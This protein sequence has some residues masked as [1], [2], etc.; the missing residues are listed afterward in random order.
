MSGEV[1]VRGLAGLDE[2][3]AA[4]T[5][6]R[7][8][9]GHTH[10]AYGLSPHLLAAL[11]A[12]AGSVIGAF[13]A[14][15]ELI[16]FCFGFTAVDAGELYH[17]SQAAVVHPSAQGTGVGRLLKQAQAATARATGA[18]TMRWTFDPYAVRNAHFN[19]AVLGAT[20]VRFLPDYYGGDTDR[21]LV[22]WDLTGPPRRAEPTRTVPGGKRDELRRGLQ[23]AFDDGGR[24]VGVRRDPVAYL[25]ELEER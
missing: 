9:F 2:R 25:F 18:R 4:A 20:G 11:Q 8:V 23:R 6:Y 13:A 16:G 12:N 1:T 7:S 14:D 15:G 10:P 22:S 19:L 5:L 17:Y 24:L 3:V 21:V